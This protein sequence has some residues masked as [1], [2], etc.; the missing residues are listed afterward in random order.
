MNG[1]AIW[2]SPCWLCG[3]SFMFDIDRV[4]SIL[5]DTVTRLAPDLGGDPSRAEREPVCPSCCKT[6][7]AERR[8]RGMTV[9]F[10]ERDSL[11]P[12]RQEEAL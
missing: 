10:D 1:V 4:A 9:F 2:I 7:N 3:H 5:I 11:D 12:A 6:A 8:K